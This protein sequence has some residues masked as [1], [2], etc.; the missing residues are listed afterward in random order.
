MNHL[1][2]SI[3]LLL[4]HRPVKKKTPQACKP[5]VIPLR[6][7]VKVVLILELLNTTAAVDELLLTCKER[8]A[9]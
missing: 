9:R 6:V 3:S 4:L 5:E 8:M 2:A 7:L 1:L